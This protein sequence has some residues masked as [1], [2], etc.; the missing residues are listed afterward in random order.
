MSEFLKKKL[1][2]LENFPHEVQ[3]SGVENKCRCFDKN[4]NKISWKKMADQKTFF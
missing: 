4:L 2:K 1:E 3:K